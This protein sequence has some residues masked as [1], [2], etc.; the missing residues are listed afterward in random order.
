M[1]Y[2]EKSRGVPPVPPVPSNLNPTSWE[3]VDLHDEPHKPAPQIRRFYETNPGI[4]PYLGL[5]ARLSQIWFNRW[6]VLLLLVL[7]RVLLLTGSLNDN[8]GDAKVKALSACTKVEDVGSAMAS[9]PHYLSV[10]VNS[11]AAD[12]ISKT[13]RGLTQ[14]L[15]M[16]LMGVEALIMFVINFYIG[17]I[18]CMVSALIHG[19][20]DVAIGAVEGATDVMNKA[21]GSITDG[22][23]SDLGSLQTTVNDLVGGVA[24]LIGKE[25]PKIEVSG[26]IND[27]KNIKV[28]SSSF[29]RG[30]DSLNKT[31]PNF[32]QIEKLGKD[33]LS[34][35]FKLVTDQLDAKLGNYSFDRSVFP[36]AEKQALSFCSSNSFLNEFFTTLFEI[37]K[38]GKIAFAV[39]IPILAVLAMLVM[40]FFEIK[41]WRREKMRAKVFTENGYDPM[42]VVYIASRPMTA[43]A[44][45]KL[46]SRFKGK[47]NLV[48]RWAIAYATSLPALFV[49]SLAIAGFFSCLCQFVLLRAIEKEAPAL[50]N[51]VGDFAGDVVQTLEAVSTD[52]AVDANAGI[53]NIQNDIND[54]LLG[55]VREATSA[56]NK[57]LN[58][59]DTELNDG[60]TNVFKDTVL[61]N[62]ARQIANCLIGRKIDAIERGLTWVHDN[63]K[64]TLPLFPNDTFSQGAGD[65]VNGDSD[66]KSFLASP[67]AVTTDEVS[68]AVQSV[69]KTLHDGIIQ[70]AL[71]STALLLVYIIVV[72]TGVVWALVDMAGRD[73]MRGEG[74]QKYDITHPRP[75][76]S[77]PP[78]THNDNPFDDRAGVPAP[79]Y[80]E[81]VYAGAVPRKTGVARYPSHTRKSSY[82]DMEDAGR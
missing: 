46:A 5:R 55:W 39:V 25:A 57:T 61:L 11:L 49:L 64:I 41:R 63:A 40:G 70:E 33:A 1:A 22:I 9:M 47:K 60:I 79:D 31:I 48:A 23:T 56:V 36:V 43:G 58:T 54:D 28:D 73:K 45:I 67:S 17:T 16:I 38:K 15:K 62:T 51:Q 8:I 80:N 66:L 29:V 2:S 34:I 50:V 59:I 75:S 71:I 52:W 81:V 21:I 19:T 27:L 68:G 32:D 78:M 12:G 35:P 20:L 42:D 18:V 37:V 69:I 14:V 76:P 7:V 65:S 30:L 13:V 44:G 3:M 4:T 6:T 74:G 24:N 10:G 82:P 72:L 77:P 53:L 26:R